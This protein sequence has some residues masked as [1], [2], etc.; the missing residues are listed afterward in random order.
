APANRLLN[1]P[2]KRCVLGLELLAQ[3]GDLALQGL[4]AALA[5]LFLACDLLA[6]GRQAA[7]S[8]ASLASTTDSNCPATRP[9]SGFLRVRGWHQKYS[10]RFFRRDPGAP[11][12]P[13]S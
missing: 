6:S 9:V 2:L 8:S 7:S 10:L 3:L 11:S 1:I 13:R 4:L 12:R 5:L